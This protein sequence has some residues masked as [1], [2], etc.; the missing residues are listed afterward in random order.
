MT[1]W[2]FSSEGLVHEADRAALVHGLHEITGQIA[3]ILGT[4]LV[5]Q[6]YIKERVP[7]NKMEFFNGI[8]HD[9]TKGG[10]GS[11]VPLRFFHF[12][13]LKNHIFFNLYSRLLADFL[14]HVING[15]NWSNL[16]R[17]WVFLAW[18]GWIHPWAKR[19]FHLIWDRA[20]FGFFRCASISWFE[21]VSQWF[22]HLFQIFSKS[23][24]SSN[25]S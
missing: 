6:V 25:S 4:D 16:R 19:F 22:I 13:L 10:E 1:C 12:F 14:S 20:R 17:I 2:L 8:V 7:K 15:S 21:V 3:E 24:N 9:S 11:L 18:E 5:P 23:S